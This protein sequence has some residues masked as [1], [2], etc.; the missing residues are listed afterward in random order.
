MKLLKRKFSKQTQSKGG[1]TTT[2]TLV[3]T[4]KRIYKN[5]FREDCISVKLQA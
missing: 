2:T 4:Q 1:L 5:V 3:M